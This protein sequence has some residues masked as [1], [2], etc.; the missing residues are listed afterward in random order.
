M[1]NW[2]CNNLSINTANNDK[3]LEFLNKLYEEANKGRLNEFTIPFSDM[4]LKEWNYDACLIHWGTKWDAKQVIADIMKDDNNINIEYT[5]K[6]NILYEFDKFKNDEPNAFIKTMN[7]NL[8]NSSYIN[9]YDF[10]YNNVAFPS[11][12][13]TVLFLV[14]SLCRFHPRNWGTS[15]VFL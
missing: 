14:S 13:V 11:F 15:I 2:C 12:C 4:G 6:Y 10:I 5:D 9:M 7:H 3:T 8:Y 1:P